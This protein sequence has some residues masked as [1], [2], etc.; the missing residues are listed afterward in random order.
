MLFEFAPFEDQFETEE[1]V[2]MREKILK[3]VFIDQL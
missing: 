3:E 2:S 1:I